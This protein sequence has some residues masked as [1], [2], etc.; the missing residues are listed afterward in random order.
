MG[1]GLNGEDLNEVGVLGG[2][3]VQRVLGLEAREL[4]VQTAQLHDLRSDGLQQHL[5]LDI[6]LH[7][8]CATA[9][10]RRDARV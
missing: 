7:L 2:A 6:L 8:Q 1:C 10:Q 9:T 4:V 3:L 5:R